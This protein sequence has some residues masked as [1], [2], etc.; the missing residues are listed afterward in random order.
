[1]LVQLSPKEMSQCNQAA[2][3]RW[4]LAR[5]SGIVNQR[6]DQVKSQQDLDLLGVKAEL[7]V[8]RVFNL[9]HQHAVGVDDGRDIWLDDISIDVKATFHKSGRLLFK[10]KQSF[11]ADCAVLVCQIE[12]NKMNVVGYASH[13][14]FMDK[15]KEVDLGYGP[16]MAMD[17]DELNSLERL[18]YAGRMSGL[19]F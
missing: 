19:K 18:W 16:C 11:K 15:A 7:A 12:L 10:D 8:S 9:E 4:Q 1:M 13:A 14:L 17:Q 6:R 3:M 5:A 2:A